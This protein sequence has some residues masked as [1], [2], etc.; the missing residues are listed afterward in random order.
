M[1]F[2]PQDYDVKP[3]GAAGLTERTVLDGSEN[4]SPRWP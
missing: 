2:N 1:A 4:T 3:I